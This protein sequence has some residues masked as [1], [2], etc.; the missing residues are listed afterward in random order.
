MSM[1]CD[2]ISIKKTKDKKTEQEKKKKI[3]QAHL[4]PFSKPE[5][6]LLPQTAV[7]AEPDPLDTAAV[8]TIPSDSDSTGSCVEILD[9]SSA[10]DICGGTD[11]VR[12]GRTYDEVR[13]RA[14]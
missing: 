7:F 1:M 11:L 5:K 14:H 3:W 13:Q 12:F 8:P 6:T 10:V 4:S 9:G 2:T